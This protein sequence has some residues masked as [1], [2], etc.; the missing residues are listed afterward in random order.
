MLA[1]ALCRAGHGAGLSERARHA[2][3]LQGVDS[4]FTLRDSMF[5]NNSATFG[6]AID[7]VGGGLSVFNC[8][9]YGNSGSQV[10]LPGALKCLAWPPR[11]RPPGAPAAHL[12]A[13][14]VQVL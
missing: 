11:A 5:L 3:A 1:S 8:T 7:M 6:G 2:G 14:V 13:G 4:T 10:L 12:G 9:F